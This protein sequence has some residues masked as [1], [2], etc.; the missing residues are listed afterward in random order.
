MGRMDEL[1][2]WEKGYGYVYIIIELFKIANNEQEKIERD[3]I[4]MS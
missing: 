1:Y 4:G 2:E 3:V